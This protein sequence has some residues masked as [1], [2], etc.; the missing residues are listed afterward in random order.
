LSPSVD[1]ALRLR[2]ASQIRQS[3]SGWRL[4]FAYAT[5]SMRHPSTHCPRKHTWFTHTWP[6]PPQLKGSEPRVAHGASS[7]QHAEPAPHADPVQTPALHAS[8]LVQAFPS[9]HGVPSA[10]DRG[11]HWP[12]AGLQSETSDWHA[13]GN[14]LAGQMTGGPPT[15]APATHVSPLVQ[16]F[17]SLQVV[18]S[19]F[20]GYT[21]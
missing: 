6:Q 3:L 9:S 10:L 15:H 11:T 5:P 16:A 1:Q 17:W 20:A 4:P 2:L 14:G 18:P 21:H 19:P 12:V 8:A 7:E 13:A